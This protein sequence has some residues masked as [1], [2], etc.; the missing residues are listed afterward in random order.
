MKVTVQ[1]DEF[2]LVDY[3]AD[4]ISALAR[5]VSSDA[6]LPDDLHITIEVDETTPLGRARVASVDPLVL[7]VQ[8]GA[9]E[10]PTEPRQF[11]DSVSGDVMG[12][13]LFR[14]SDRLS[15]DFGDPPLDED[16]TLAHRSAWDTYAVGRLHRAGYPSQRQ[17]RLYAFRTRHGFT[18]TADRAFQRLWTADGLT[19]ADLVALSDDA[20][21]A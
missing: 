4:T 10:E 16:L 11:S 15:P 1:P 20:A 12:R 21:A 19:W 18:D 5:R 7:T 17:R 14:V 3:D 13:L 2:T 6:G 8:S 9:F